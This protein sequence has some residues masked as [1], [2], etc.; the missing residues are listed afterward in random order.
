MSPDDA[1]LA[2]S[3]MERQGKNFNQEQL[4]AYMS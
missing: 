2:R 4:I 3:F 1:K